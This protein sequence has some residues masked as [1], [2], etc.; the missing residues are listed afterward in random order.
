MRAQGVG[1]VILGSTEIALLISQ[2]DVSL[3]VFDTTSLHAQ[4]AVT[5]ALE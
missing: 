1:G 4:A 3:P 2:E 5:R